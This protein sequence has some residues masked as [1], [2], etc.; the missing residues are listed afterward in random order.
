MGPVLAA[1]LATPLEVRLS[2][3]TIVRG[4]SAAEL[5]ALVRARRLLFGGRLVVTALMQNQR[6]DRLVRIADKFDLGVHHLEEEFV[7]CFREDGE[8]RLA[9][10]LLHQ[11]L[12]LKRYRDREGRGQRIGAGCIV[13]GPRRTR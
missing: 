6:G 8:L 9:G 5:A 4:S 11:L 12:A 13:S 7:F 2:D 10:G 3:G 1:S